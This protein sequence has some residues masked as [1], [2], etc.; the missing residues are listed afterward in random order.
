MPHP[1]NQL[2]DEAFDALIA[3]ERAHVSPPLTEWRTLAAQLREEGLIRASNEPSEPAPVA[4]P[5]HQ[6]ALPQYRMQSRGVRY[7]GMRVVTG[8]ALLGIGIIA[9]HGWP[10]KT[11]AV[12][13][14][15][16]GVHETPAADSG[17]VTSQ[18]NDTT[19]RLVSN[20]TVP[21]SSPEDAKQALLKAQMD[22]QR[23]VAYLA[24]SDTSAQIV[25]GRP[26]SRQVYQLRLAAL[27]TV[28]LATQRALKDAPHDPLLHQYYQSAVG[29]H[30]ATEQQ[31]A[32]V[33]PVGVQVS[34]F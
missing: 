25:T 16:N 2:P 34:H 19:A 26:Q 12:A 22:Y 20:T 18:N 7:W 13:A 28:M 29:A 30:E 27:D 10:V 21:F 32:Q 4:L 33:V 3:R 11:Q 1:S 24:A 17:A 31:L 15:T 9:G 5:G 14:A 6:A 8:V 23:A